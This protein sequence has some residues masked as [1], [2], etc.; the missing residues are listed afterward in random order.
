MD[1]L[2]NLQSTYH[3]WGPAYLNLQ[4]TLFIIYTVLY[5]QSTYYMA[6]KIFNQHIQTFQ[7]PEPELKSFKNPYG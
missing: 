7:Q 4:S 1:I 3:Y 6:T 5:L 2:E